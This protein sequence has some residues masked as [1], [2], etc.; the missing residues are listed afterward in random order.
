LSALGVDAK[1]G[2]TA[3]EAKTFAGQSIDALGEVVKTGW[4]DP[5]ELKE[6][7][8]DAVRSRADFQKLVAEVEAKAERPQVAK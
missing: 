5:S 7:D 2:V 4:A 1:S 8:F 6:P 3:A